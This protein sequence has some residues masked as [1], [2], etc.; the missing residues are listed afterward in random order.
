MITNDTI[1]LGE[2]GSLL[3]CVVVWRPRSAVNWYYQCCFCGLLVKF[4]TTRVKTGVVS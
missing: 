3:C 1:Q 4:L 2:A